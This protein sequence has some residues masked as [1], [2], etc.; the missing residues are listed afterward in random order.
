MLKTILP[1]ALLQL[2]SSPSPSASGSSVG[3]EPA[4]LVE[5]SLLLT[6]EVLLLQ[7]GC[8]RIASLVSKLWISLFDKWKQHHCLQLPRE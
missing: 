6:A 1:K 7:M 4:T 2:L 8:A 3:R 5:T